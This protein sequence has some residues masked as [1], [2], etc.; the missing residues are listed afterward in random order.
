[1][2]T[3]FMVVN[4]NPVKWFSKD[5][6]I[7]VADKV[8]NEHFGGTYV[9]YLVVEGGSEGAMKNPEVAQYVGKI[10][11][12]LED[13][14]VVGKTT[15]YVD[16]VKKVS[17]E[18]NDEDKAFDVVPDNRKA[19]AQYLFLYEMSGN[20]DDLYHL[21]DS[22]YEKANIWVHLTSGDNKDMVAV[23]ESL[24]EFFQSNPP[25]V[26]VSSWWAG[27]TYLNVVWQD[28]MVSGMLSALAGSAIVVFLMMTLLFRSPVWGFVTM[29]PLTL[30]I[31]FIYGL[32]GYVGK[33]Y[34]MPIAVLSAL[35]LGI[36]IDF[37]IHLSQ[38]AR[39]IR[40]KTESW[41]E[42]VIELY[43]EPVR[44][45]ARNMFV[46]TIG[47][48]PLLLSSLLPY[49]TVGVFFAAIMAVSG[50]ATLIILPSIMTVIKGA[51]KLK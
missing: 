48:S 28:K 42:A 36:S 37:A 5:H 47:F 45:I 30:T 18:L 13:L 40:A 6:D 27:L 39:Q 1:D 22:S 32:V 10:Q 44:A 35:T 50:V 8:L 31:A 12:S 25:P 20:P 49:K 38:R 46:I 34:D 23:T 14:S 7:R 43:G 9:A 11:G 41:S 2:G 15:S 26:G 33:D 24:D 17:F 19:I 29:I 4:D 3:S 21:V 51:L 16:V